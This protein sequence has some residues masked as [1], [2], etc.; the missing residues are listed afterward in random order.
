MRLLKPI[1]LCI[2]WLISAI[3]SALAYP[4]SIQG[5]K[6]VD[7]TD[8]PAISASKAPGEPSRDTGT[9]SRPKP[10]DR[11]TINFDDAD[12]RTVI[13]F[14]SELT[15]K[16]FLVDDRVKGTVTILSPTDITVDEA[17]LV[18]L[19][20]L[21]M[22]GFT[23]VEAGKITK[24]VPSREARH[25]DILTL[26]AREM[27]AVRREDRI[28]TQIIPLNYANANELKGML[29]P[30]V[31]KESDI[32]AYPPTN[33][34][35]ITDYAS[36]IHRLLSIIQ[37]MD[38]EGAEE[39][40]TVIPLR[41]ASAQTLVTELLSLV[42]TR[43]PTPVVR[44]TPRPGSPAGREQSTFRVSKLIADERTNSLILVANVADT[45]KLMSLVKK[46]DRPL[47]PGLNRIHVH[48]LEN[49]SSDE[50]VAVLSQLP[51]KAA[52]QQPGQGPTGARAPVLGEDVQILA[53][54]PTNSLIIIAS[55]QDYATLEGVITK[56]D[57][58]RSQVL[59]ES[60]IAE[61][62]MDRLKEVGVQWTYLSHESAPD[63]VRYF[64]ASN[65]DRP[66]IGLDQQGA[67]SNLGDLFSLGG[68]V[69]GVFKGPITIA[70][71]EFLNLSALVRA[72]QDVSDV[73][74]LS[75]PH[76]LTLDNEEA[77]IVV[78]ENRPF[79][80][81]QTGTAESVVATD[82]GGTTAVVQTFEFKD[83]GITLR[84]TPQ[85]SR[86]EFVRLSIDQ[87]VSNV[88]ETSA[89]LAS[90]GAFSTFK[91]QTKTTV[92]VEDGQT[93]VIGGLIQDTK[94][95]GQS[96]TPCLANIPGLGAL[97]RTRRASESK[98]NLLIFI[99]PHILATPQEMAEITEKKR[100]ES[101]ARKEEYQQWRS[102]DFQDTLD[103][104]VE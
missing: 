72:F 47:P 22:K 16:N 74:V 79:L 21:E 31:S 37:D 41:H 88:I 77:E 24:I 20:A 97:F 35:I 61:V 59:V 7:E 83:V 8:E 23:V 82:E 6:L 103:M 40:I 68:L 14:I 19:S 92:V 17:Y 85:I 71:Q 39:R 54:K 44:R 10:S 63:D 76:I 86:S 34:L 53:D 33:T 48:Y 51:A 62:S 25:R 64:G 18:F 1:D 42:E 43:A 95:R 27:G 46:L 12:L 69:M 49:A 90:Q 45:E 67:P 73:N 28:I 100:Q 15:G 4:T 78:A 75:T 98:R 60:L 101:D 87:E 30:L 57:I 96:G 91:R 104:I 81:S 66:Q 70:G 3:L 56:L 38:A 11:I 58:M 55:P 99:T 52:A 2:L 13:K 36:N 93:V 84:I 32:V 102:R 26:K 29:T 89:Q 5:V 80:K 50:L 65:V 9:S 94:T